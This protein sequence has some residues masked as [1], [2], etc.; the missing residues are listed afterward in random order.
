MGNK[1][2]WR[3]VDGSHN[4]IDMPDL[5]KVRSSQLQLFRACSAV[6]FRLVHLTPDQFNKPIHYPKINSQTLIS[7]SIRERQ[8]FM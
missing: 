3:T 8:M 1:Y 7:Y 2:A 6:F 4:N 5:G